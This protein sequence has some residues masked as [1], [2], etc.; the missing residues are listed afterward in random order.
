[1]N[2]IPPER[3]QNNFQIFEVIRPEVDQIWTESPQ[4]RNRDAEVCY[5]HAIVGL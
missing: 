3:H 1:M 5:M 4:V 2:T